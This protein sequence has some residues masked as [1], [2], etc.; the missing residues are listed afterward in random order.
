MVLVGGSGRL[1]NVAVGACDSVESA[2]AK[3]DGK[4]FGVVFHHM[5]VV[6]ERCSPSLRLL[7]EDETPFGS[8]EFLE[9]VGRAAW[10]SQVDSICREAVGRKG[11]VGKGC[12]SVVCGPVYEWCLLWWGLCSGVRVG[13]RKLLWGA[14]N[15]S[16]SCG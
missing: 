6:V 13:V 2:S 12:G 11:D 8:K 10:G 5:V 9:V 15:L 3:A 7:E 14:W 4:L 16:E 1:E